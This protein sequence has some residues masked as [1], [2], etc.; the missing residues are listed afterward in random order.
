MIDFPL[1]AGIL[2]SMLHVI[3]GPDHLAAVTPL[4]IE[5]EKK[6]W[7]IGLFWG[8]G[9]I[10]GM[11]L[12][13]GLF[14]VFAAHIPV[15]RI[16]EHSEKLVG[17]VLIGVGLWAF[18][19]LFNEKRSPSKI[20]SRTDKK[21]ILSSLGIGILHGFAGIAHFLLLLP[22]LGFKTNFEG[23]QYIIGFGIGTVLVMTI[24]AFL[25]GK[26]TYFTK[27]QNAQFFNGIR[28]SGGIFA[29]VIGIY[30]LYLGF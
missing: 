5:T 22:V 10:A 29:T 16:S 21:S 25:L 17:I 27:R 3:S 30:W 1:I 9:H 23:T 4:A 13:G 28:F 24:Y 18:Y 8:I 15:E 11:L 19:K 2:A 12:I 6:T 20:L 26:A 14:L 7:K